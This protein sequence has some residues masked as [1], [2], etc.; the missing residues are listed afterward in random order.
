MVGPLT[1]LDVPI[2]AFAGTEDPAAPPALMHGWRAETSA[3]FTLDPIPGGHFFDPA[4]E[5]Q[6]IRAIGNDLVRR[7]RD[8]SHGRRR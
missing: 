3:H 5:R 4:G 8:A 7:R 1:P 2:R 6:V